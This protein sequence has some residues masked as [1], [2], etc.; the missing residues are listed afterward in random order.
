VFTAAV[1]TTAGLFEALS[2]LSRR[3]LAPVAEQFDRPSGLYLLPPP[4]QRAESDAI[5]DERQAIL[6]EG[7]IEELFAEMFSIRS[8]VA[9][10]RDEVH[11]LRVSQSGDEAA[12]QP[13]SRRLRVA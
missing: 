5:G 12:E 9:Q 3:R 1:M 8:S 7:L 11:L 6:D 10:L 2:A 4:T 13:A